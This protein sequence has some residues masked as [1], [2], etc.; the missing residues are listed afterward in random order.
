M[1]IFYSNLNKN[2]L[3]FEWTLVTRTI[4]IGLIRNHDFEFEYEL[5]LNFEFNLNSNLNLNLNL[6]L[7]LNLKLNLNLDLSLS[8]DIE[9]NV[10]IEFEFDFGVNPC[11]KSIIQKINFLKNK[12]CIFL[13]FLKIWKT[14]FLQIYISKIKFW[15]IGKN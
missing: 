12:N 14:N 15:K 8:L 11:M 9:P 1:A 2:W 10:G 6:S 3:K 5:K 7:K 13:H 4:P